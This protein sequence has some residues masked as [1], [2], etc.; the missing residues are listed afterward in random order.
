M[1]SQKRSYLLAFESKTTKHCKRI[2]F[3]DI[4]NFQLDKVLDVVRKQHEFEQK[5]KF[6]EIHG[7]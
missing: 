3:N 6:Y 1:L 5:L 7:Y 4:D 2:R